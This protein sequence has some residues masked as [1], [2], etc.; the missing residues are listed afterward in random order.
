MHRVTFQVCG[1]ART[2]TDTVDDHRLGQMFLDRYAATLEAAGG[3]VTYSSPPPA[4]PRARPGTTPAS[5]C[6]GPST[7]PPS[8]TR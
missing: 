5:D 7:T 6:A 1:I 2:L 8:G 3:A 4:R